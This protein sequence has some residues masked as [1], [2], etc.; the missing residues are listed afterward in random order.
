MT[1]WTPDYRVKVNGD[2]ITDIT[3][4]GFSIT[5]GRTDTLTQAQAGYCSLRVL[6]TGNIAYSWS[7]NTAITIEVKDSTSTFVPIFGGRISDITYSVES[8]GALGFVTAIDIYALGGISRLQKSIWEGSLNKDLDGAQILAIVGSL[9]AE[10]WNSVPPAE[11]WQDLNPTT[12]WFEAFNVLVGDIDDGEYE[13][14]ARTASPINQYS[15]IADIANS[16]LGYIYENGYG[17]VCYADA[18]HREN[19]LSANGY[20][21]L[22]AREAN[23]AGIKATTRQGDLINKMVIN[24]KN[25]FGTNYSFTNT[26]S[27]TLYGTYG[28]SVNSLIDD[29]PDAEAVTERTVNLR[30]YPRP[31]LESITYALQNPELS[32]TDRDALISVFMGMPVSIDNLP[33]NINSGRFEGFVEGFTFRSSLSGLSL[34]FFAS[35]ASFSV[36]NRNW[37]EVN[38]AEQFNTL[39]GTLTWRLATGV[40]N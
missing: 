28:I 25:N 12:R 7:I 20:V 34:T 1:V 18:R 23:W 14:I 24:Y 4:V 3:L 15:Y 27:E 39:S 21:E 31:K 10:T 40:I 36:F 5:S 32:N 22:D 6:N 8:A 16:S 30:A 38:P 11:E 26:A 35:D 13:M 33:P 29:D 37:S 17:L 9:Y 19:Y 2:E